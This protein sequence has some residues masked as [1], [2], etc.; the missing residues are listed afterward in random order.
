MATVNLSYCNGAWG[1]SIAI[2]YND[3]THE[4]DSGTQTGPCGP[5]GLPSGIEIYSHTEGGTTYKVFTQNAAP[6]AYVSTFTVAPCSVVI[7]SVAVGNASTNYASDGSLIVTATANGPKSYSLDGVTW[8][9]SNQFTGLA[10]GSYTVRARAM[11]EGEFCYDEEIVAVGFADVVCELELGNISK[12]ADTGAGNG[13]IT[14]NTLVNPPVLQVEYRIDAGAWQDSPSFTELSAGTYNVQVRYKD[15]TDCTDDKDITVADQDC[16]IIIQQVIVTHEQAKYADN[17]ALEIIATS[18][19]G[20]LEYSIDGGESYEDS[21]FFPD[22]SPGVYEIAVKDSAGCVDTT[23]VTLRKYK[24]PYLVIPRVN[25]HRFVIT[26][27]PMVDA[28]RQTFDNKLFASM[29]FEGVP[30]Q[31]FHEKV[32][33]SDINTIQFRSNYTTNT[34]KVYDDANTL[35]ATMAATRKTSNLDKSDTGDAFFAGYGDDKTQI[36]FEHGLPVHY[37]IGMDIT[38]AG[39]A[40]LNGTYEIVDI[41][42]GVGEALGYVVLVVEKTYTSETAIT[43]GTVTVIFD[44][45]PYEV[46]EV[47]VDWNNWG[48]G[49]FYMLLEGSDEQLSEYKARSEPA[50]VKT[51]WPDHLVI[52]Y[53]NYENGYQVDYD[54]GITFQIRVNA[55][56]KWPLNS[57]KRTVM[58]DSRRRLIKVEAYTSRVA[59]FIG[60][61]M[62]YYELEKVAM[63]FDHDFF[64]VDGVEYQTEEDCV[65]EYFGNDPFGNT[66]AKLRQVEFEAE[67]TDDLGPADV[68]LTIL[69]VDDSLLAIDP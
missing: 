45:E 17:G 29:K 2:V 27:G 67:N 44:L 47:G 69:D 60:Y 31:C 8:Q 61:D 1:A 18:G 49:K 50:H 39:E 42:Q 68:D 3:A 6:Y 23:E 7:A 21:N 48:E 57:G 12:T 52:R 43:S 5:S 35:K 46:W 11:K 13:S 62:P 22:L 55:E 32:E 24:E 63:A 59:Q 19:E 51:S 10:P 16:D 9:S 4:I 28:A 58:E 37:E 56:L 33:V 26:E 30:G 38:I 53:K 64:S 14:V 20:G 40:T 15:F 65:H 66:S 54:T 41:A 36:F 34:L 25:A